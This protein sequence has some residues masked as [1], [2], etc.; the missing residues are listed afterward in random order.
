[1][2]KIRACWSSQTQTQMLSSSPLVYMWEPEAND[3]YCSEQI[4]F[5]LGWGF[6]DKSCHNWYDRRCNPWVKREDTKAKGGNGSQWMSK[7]N[8]ENVE[9]PILVNQLYVIIPVAGGWVGV[10]R[11][12]AFTQRPFGFS[13]WPPLKWFF[14]FQSCPTVILQL[15][16]WKNSGK[17]NIVVATQR[18][19]I[20][21]SI[22]SH[23][24]LGTEG[25]SQDT[26]WNK[27]KGLLWIHV[28]NFILRAFHCKSV[29]LMFRAAEKVM[30]ALGACRCML[31]FGLLSA[32]VSLGSWPICLG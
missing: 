12:W 5:R 10:F 1:M 3:S 18:N 16:V 26:L 4:F 6:T 21:Q 19:L 17:F 15:R 27:D 32:K 14:F 25:T 9:S 7:A 13:K 29:L 24:P 30:K 11:T 23:K 2:H 20:R 28:S 22:S 8:R 31:P